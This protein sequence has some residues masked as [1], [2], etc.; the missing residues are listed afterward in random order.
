MLQIVDGLDDLISSGFAEQL[1]IIKKQL[2][3]DIQ[4][5]VL[6]ATFSEEVVKATKQWL[7][8]PIHR[9]VSDSVPPASSACITQTVS[10][11][12]TAESKLAK[13]RFLRSEGCYCSAL[14]AI[15]MAM[16]LF[17]MLLCL[18]LSSGENPLKNL[19]SF[20]YNAVPCI[21]KVIP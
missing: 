20:E 16:N 10:V 4:V 6:S 18:V 3:P 12:T 2:Q 13:V 19:H 7:Q 9:A 11:V 1:N 15:V 5:G 14:L 8:D 21:V 17:D